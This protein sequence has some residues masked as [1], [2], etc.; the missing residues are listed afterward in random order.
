MGIFKACDVRGVYPDEL[1]E[2][3]AEQIGRA[4]GAQVREH[5]GGAAECVLAGDVRESTPAL[6]SALCR[7]LV[8]AGVR[9][10]DV[11]IVPTPVA[12]WARRHRGADAVAIVTASHNPPRYNGV[13]FMIGELPVTETDVERL[14]RQVAEGAAPAAPGGG[15]AQWDPRAPYVEWLG[16]RFAG[17]GADRKVVVDAGNGAWWRLAPEAM[18]AAGYEVA[19][20]FCTP[21]GQFP[22]RSPDP[23]APG[24]LE[25]AAAL[26]RSTDAELAACFDGDGDRVAFLD[27]RGDIVPAEE[28]LILLARDALAEA[29]GEAVVYDRKCTRMVPREVERAGGRPVTERS[30]HTFVKRRLIEEDAL[31]GGEASGHFFFGELAGDDGLYA[32]LRLGEALHVAGRSLA[33]LRGTIPPYFIS[34]DIRIARPAGDAA[35]VVEALRRQFADR[36]QDR[37]DGVLVEFDGGW[38]LCRASVTEPAVT[39]RVEGETPERMEQ[40]RAQVLAAIQSPT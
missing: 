5:A 2:T 19:E 21:D 18:R 36:P 8:E 28:A 1:D 22:N 38:A 25:K 24:A 4:I 15:L 11:G 29:P 12:Y 13:K 37:T 27:E 16:R 33:E 35:Q 9:V 34:E 39:V 17:T 7:G 40:I 3:A 30:G 31:L 26:V 6:K 20:L 10:C 32:A 14:R 23:S